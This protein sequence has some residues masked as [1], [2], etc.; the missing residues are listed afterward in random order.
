MRVTAG[1]VPVQ[2]ESETLVPSLLRQT[3]ERVWV[4]DDEQVFDDGPQPLV[5]LFGVQA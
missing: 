4:A 2:L 1:F 3:T 5:V